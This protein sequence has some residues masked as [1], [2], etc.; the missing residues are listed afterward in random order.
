MRVKERV[1]RAFTRNLF[2]KG[3]SLFLALL[4]WYHVSR[5]GQEYL[6]V[7]VPVVLSHLPKKLELL[8]SVPQHVTITLSGP[9]GLA[10]RISPRSLTALVDGTLFSAG[11]R[12]VSLSPD[13]IAIP[14][15]VQIKQISPDSVFVHLE[16]LLRKKVPIYPQFVGSVRGRLPVFHISFT[17]QFALVEGDAQTLKDLKRIRMT[18]IDLSQIATPGHQI[19]SIPLAPPANA[20]YR[21][22]SPESV[23]VRIDLGRGPRH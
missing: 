8:S 16:S 4:V 5:K 18:P 14:G 13:M 17:P 7:Q 9:P 2:L 11:I 1:R 22:L 3:F 6:S 19:I 21:I 12:K 15:G 10:R 20:R 23:Q